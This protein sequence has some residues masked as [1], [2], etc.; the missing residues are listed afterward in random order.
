[1]FYN[2][3]QINTVYPLFDALEKCRGVAQM[4][5]HHPEG[6]VFIHSVQVLQWAMKESDDIDLVVAAMLH[7][8]GKC[9]DSKGHEKYGLKMLDGHISE[10]TAWLIENHMRVWYLILGEM[11]RHKKVKELIEHEWLPDLILLA[12]WDKLGRDPNKETRYNR[13][14]LIER[15][16]FKFGD[17]DESLRNTI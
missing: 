16:I 9:I 3:K 5:I 6:D 13:I 12:R 10:K 2:F 8:V 14:E 15:F 7:D 11:R 1:M 17:G 4:E